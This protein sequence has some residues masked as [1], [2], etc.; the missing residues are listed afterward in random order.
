MN[1]E[2]LFNLA[3]FNYNMGAPGH[4]GHAGH[5]HHT[6][7]DICCKVRC[8]KKLL[9]TSRK[10]TCSKHSPGPQFAFEA[11]YYYQSAE[12]DNEFGSLKRG[13]VW[14]NFSCRSRG[15]SAEQNLPSR[16]LDK[17]SMDDNP[18]YACLMRLK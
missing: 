17:I 16:Q 5:Q 12:V 9:P 15:N 7:T 11:R 2:R 1:S 18:D 10:L 6:E 3:G 14:S 13:V 8:Q 4:A